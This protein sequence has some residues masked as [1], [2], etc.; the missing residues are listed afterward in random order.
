M[1]AESPALPQSEYRIRAKRLLKQLK[2]TEHQQLVEQAAARF[3]RL[4]SLSGMTVA[5]IVE[6]R[7]SV[8]LK[9]ALA[10]IALE[11]GYDSWKNLKSSAEAADREMYDPKM[12][13]FLN[14]WFANYDDARASLEEQGGFLFPYK[15]QFFV[16]EAGA[17]KTLGLNPEEPDW[18]LI[19][20]DWAEPRDREAW[21]RLANKRKAARR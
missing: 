16:C 7:E 2:R 3:L 4:E 5:Q 17:V 14:R 15:N 9:H 1:K 19:G 10:V 11:A 8:K 18:E 20:H 12:D 21:R 6:H 13:V